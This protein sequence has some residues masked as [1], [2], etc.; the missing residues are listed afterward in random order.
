MDL[1]LLALLCQLAFAPLLPRVA[2]AW[3]PAAF[4]GAAGPS[5]GSATT[6]P[7]PPTTTTT[8]PT[9]TRNSGVTFLLALAR[10][11][12]LRHVLVPLPWVLRRLPPRPPSRAFPATAR[13]T[14]SRSARPPFCLICRQ[15]GHL[16]E[17][18]KPPPVLKHLG[19]GIPGCG[20]FCF[21]GW[22]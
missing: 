3:L 13:G 14:F 10:A 4:M 22:W 12:S 7:P 19:M 1:A 17:D 5:S 6:S 8:T 20:F 2:V 16:I 21:G 9:K 15:E 18:C 11:S